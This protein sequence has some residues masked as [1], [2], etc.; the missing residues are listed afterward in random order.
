MKAKF[1]E[2]TQSL[3]TAFMYKIIALELSIC[4]SKPSADFACRGAALLSIDTG[5]SFEDAR[6]KL[7]SIY[8]TRSRFVHSGKLP[9]SE[10]L[11]FIDEL[12]QSVLKSMLRLRNMNKTFIKETWHKHL[13]LVA[14]TLEVGLSPIDELKSAIGG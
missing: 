10:D 13:D 7:K 8:D 12:N 5:I 2:A 6:K 1:H 11:N 4:S 9:P 3:D 14:N